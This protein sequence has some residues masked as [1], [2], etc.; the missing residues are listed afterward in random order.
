MHGILH[1]REH[2]EVFVNVY[3]YKTISSL[4][5]FLLHWKHQFIHIFFDRIFVTV[6][7]AEILNFIDVQ[8]GSHT[9][10]HVCFGSFTWNV[11]LTY[12][13]SH[14]YSHGHDV[15]HSIWC[16]LVGLLAYSVKLDMLKNNNL[17]KAI[18]RWITKQHGVFFHFSNQHCKGEGV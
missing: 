11:M 1:L 6:L 13:K 7:L 12:K 9:R 16:H 14:R 4:R 8:H 5:F 18:S 15:L 10:M 3:H 2:K 17:G